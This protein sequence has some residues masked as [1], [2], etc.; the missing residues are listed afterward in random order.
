MQLSLSGA[1]EQAGTSKSSILRAIKS[2]KLSAGRNAEGGYQIDPAEVARAFPPDRSAPR[3]ATRGAADE[4]EVGIRIR[5][6]SL[7]AQITAL[8]ELLD[9]ERRRSD[10]VRSER[11]EWR[12]S[13]QR[14]MLAAPIVATAAP[15][16]PPQRRS[17]GWWGRRAA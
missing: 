11:D 10:E 7:E 4:S 8:R 2:G 3:G 16:S 15:P 1:A 5:N 14:L 17:W 12:Q 9:A 6:A 13:A